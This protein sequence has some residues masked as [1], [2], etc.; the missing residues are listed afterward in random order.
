MKRRGDGETRGR[1]ENASK[2][3]F[4]ASPPSPCLRVNSLPCL[5]GTYSFLP[6]V[7]RRGLA[8]DDTEWAAIVSAVNFGLGEFLPSV[9]RK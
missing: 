3:S 4:S 9:R 7:R 2:L 1:G 6:R 8:V 5:R